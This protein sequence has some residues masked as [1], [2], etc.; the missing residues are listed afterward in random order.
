MS[1]IWRENENLSRFSKAILKT[2]PGKKSSVETPIPA[3][4]R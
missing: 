3:V 1:T 4:E 2:N